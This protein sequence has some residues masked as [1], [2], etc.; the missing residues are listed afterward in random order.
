MKGTYDMKIFMLIV[1]VIYLV[2]F[3]VSKCLEVEQLKKENKTLMTISESKLYKNI[4][5][6]TIDAVKYAMKHAHPDNGGSAE[7]FMRFK[8]C[9]EE[10]TRK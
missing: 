5:K 3:Y 8:R 1:V 6:N 4:P 10:L 9:Y 2:L 7:D